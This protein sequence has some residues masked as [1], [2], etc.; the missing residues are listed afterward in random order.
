M[1]GTFGWTTAGHGHPIKSVADCLLDKTKYFLSTCSNVKFLNQEWCNGDTEPSP[2]SQHS[3]CIFRLLNKCCIF[4]CCRAGWGIMV[5]WGKRKSGD[6]FV[7]ELRVNMSIKLIASIGLS[8]VV[9][10]EIISLNAVFSHCSKDYFRNS[11]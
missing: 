8:P 5:S 3:C 9:H 11:L 1:F 10:K 4:K 2:K 7:Y 6:I